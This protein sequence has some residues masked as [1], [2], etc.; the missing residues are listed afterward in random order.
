MSMHVRMRIFGFP[1][2]AAAA[3]AVLGLMGPAARAA[4]P[5]VDAQTCV[6]AGGSVEYDSATGQWVCIGGTYNK[7][8]VA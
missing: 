1:V 4:A 2:A 7:E 5:A 8:P 3:V 6:A